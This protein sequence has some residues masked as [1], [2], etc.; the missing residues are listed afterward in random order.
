[1]ILFLN[2]IG[3][4]DLQPV[5]FFDV[6]FSFLQVGGFVKFGSTAVYLMRDGNGVETTYIYFNSG[7]S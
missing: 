3:L 4:K 7:K 1:M 2:L 5:I 6:I